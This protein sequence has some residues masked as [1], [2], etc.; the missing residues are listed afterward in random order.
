MVDETISA[1]DEVKECD[2]LM[3]LCLEQQFKL[4]LPT[5]ITMHL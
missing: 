4:Q 1:E 3:E 5:K 2:E